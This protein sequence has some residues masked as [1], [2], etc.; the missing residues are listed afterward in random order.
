[1]S[2]GCPG[3]QCAT[4]TLGCSQECCIFL[5]C[6]APDVQLSGCGHFQ[7][8]TGD[9]LLYG[10]ENEWYGIGQKQLSSFPGAN[11]RSCRIF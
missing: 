2:G 6:S 1:M 5:L 10:N 7:P 11:K 8:I 3:Q 9:F 4:V